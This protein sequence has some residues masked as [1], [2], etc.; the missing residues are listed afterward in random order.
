M[1]SLRGQPFPR[2]LWSRCDPD[3]V[4]R[5]IVATTATEYT[6]PV[7]N[8]GW[9]SIAALALAVVSLF[10]E[11]AN[12]EAAW[13]LAGTNVIDYVVL[14]LTLIEVGAAFARAPVKRNY[15]NAN[16]PSLLFVLA[17]VLLFSYTKISAGI[18]GA[19][20]AEAAGSSGYLTVLIIRNLFL[21]LKVFT[22]LRKLSS[23]LTSVIARPAQTIVLSFVLV[24]VVGALVLMM[25]FTTVDGRGLPFLAALFTA[26][27]A[28]CVT[29]LIVVDT[30]VVFTIGG[31]VVILLLIQIGGLG[32]MLLSFFTIFVFRQRVSVE[33]KLLISYMLSE[34]NMNAL[35][36]AVRRI[37]LITFAIEL[38]GALV[39]LP[40]LAPSAGGPGRAV[41]F[42]LFHAVSAFC[43]AGF[44]L[45]SNSLEGFVANPAVT[46]VIA[47][48]IIA[49]GLSFA[50]ITDSVRTLRSILSG[51]RHRTRGS[52]TPPGAARRLSVNTR[53]VLIV[54]GILLVAG[55]FLIYAIEHGRS[56][57]ELPTATQYLAA[58]FQ[59]VSLRTAGF[60]TIDL[61]GLATTTYLL[62]IALMFVGGA[63]GST[64]GGIK[65][66]TVAVIV[67]Y[68]HSQRTGRRQPLLFR[69]AISDSHVATAF[70]VLVFGVVAVGSA[71]AILG[72]T[73]SFGLTEILFEAVSAFATV[74]LS[75]GVTSELSSA[76]R[77]V[78]II[79]MFVGR[80]GPLT[81]FSAI[82]ARPERTT[83]RYATADISVG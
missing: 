22:R 43:N 31:Q 9:I 15:V 75:T 28:V 64:A 69:H 41:F 29:G 8:L 23:F 68:L 42:A 44:A 32:I 30:A 62:M 60:N 34:R 72:L 40:L 3:R 55:T 16:W 71:T 11:Q 27:S 45:F 33:N 5:S 20:G 17:F 25:P 67:G 35:G 18:A 1:Q 26:T 48:L 24:I 13:I 77:I 47:L 14:V 66:N 59:A 74:G 36:S 58:F 12:L 52:R 2:A 19:S 53:S 37:I 50:V 46:V 10:V 80:V 54:S 4:A 76:G 79:L 6:A 81:L 51:V 56:I 83:I 65:V 73:E 38:A 7:R 61:G 63:S 21:L 78:I 82:S 70:T 57:A 49:G 39:L